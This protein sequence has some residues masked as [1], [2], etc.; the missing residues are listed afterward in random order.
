MQKA[1]EYIVVYVRVRTVADFPVSPVGPT[2]GQIGLYTTYT[3]QCKRLIR[4]SLA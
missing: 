3:V 2:N 4:V 1:N